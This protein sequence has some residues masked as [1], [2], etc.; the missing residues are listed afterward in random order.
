MM[1]EVHDDLILDMPVRNRKRDL[2]LVRETMEELPTLRSLM[3]L[4][5]VF[6]VDQSYGPAWGEKS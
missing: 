3:D 6:K 5:D 2:A 4:P 1:N